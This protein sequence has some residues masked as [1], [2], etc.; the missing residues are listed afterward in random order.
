[1]ALVAAASIPGSIEA[2]LIH[3]CTCAPNRGCRGC[4]RDWKPDQV[5]HWQG[6]ICLGCPAHGRLLELYVMRVRSPDDSGV[7]R[8][9]EPHT[10]VMHELR[11]RSLFVRMGYA[12]RG[13]LAW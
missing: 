10:P 5:E 7:R 3:G 2:R 9:G 4:Q 8:L 13:W 6:L 12:I 11:R 1:M